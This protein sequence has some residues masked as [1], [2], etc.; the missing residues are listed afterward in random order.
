MVDDNAAEPPPT[1]HFEAMLDANL[2]EKKRV[3]IKTGLTHV[4]E[5]CQDTPGLVKGRS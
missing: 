4:R 5:V 1:K 3:E 2:V